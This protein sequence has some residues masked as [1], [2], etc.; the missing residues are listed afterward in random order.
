MLGYL[1]PITNNLG[2]YDLGT[3]LT[4][5]FSMQ[6]YSYAVLFI[7]LI[8]DV[9][10]LIFVVVSCLLIYSLLLIS[11]ETKTF[12]IGVMRLVGLTKCGF[13]GMILTQS[14]LFVLPSVVLGFGLAIP[15]IYYV[16]SLLFSD[17]LGF[18]PSFW[19]DPIATIEALSIGILIPLFSSIIPIR[20][21]LSMNLTESLNTQRAKTSGT[22]ISFIDNSSKNLIPYILFGVVSVTFGVVVYYFLPL[23][24]LSQDFGMILMIFFAILL[25]MMAGLTLLVSNLQG[26]LEIILVYVFFF[27]EQKSMRTLLWKN[28]GAHKQRNYLT[29]IIYALTLGCIIFLLVTANLEVQSISAAS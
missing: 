29:S 7:G 4:L 2:L 18:T 10:L 15:S 5:L 8:F 20:R 3:N 1:Y 22:V 6:T 23:G 26:F 21:A 19:P 25:G 17:N 24:L 16:Y 27:W 14:A 9:L 11:V 13:T 12:E 28:L